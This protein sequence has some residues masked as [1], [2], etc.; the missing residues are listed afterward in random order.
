LRLG[1][2]QAHLVTWQ[3][4][5]TR[6]EATFDPGVRPLLAHAHRL[7]YLRPVEG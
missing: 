1:S 5:L 2:E 6:A 7:R 3:E 4:L